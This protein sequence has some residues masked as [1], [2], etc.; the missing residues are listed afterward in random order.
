MRPRR[1]GRTGRAILDDVLHNAMARSRRVLADPPQGGSGMRINLGGVLVDDQEKAARV[2]DGIPF[3]S[4][5]A[6]GSP[7]EGERQRLPCEVAGCTPGGSSKSG[8]S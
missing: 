3:T 5:A 8:R 2:A 4:F 7:R 6:P 1:C